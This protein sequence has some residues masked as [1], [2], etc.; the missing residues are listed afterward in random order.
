MQ[1]RSMDFNITEHEKF[2]AV[3]SDS[4]LPLTL[5]KPPFVE[6]WGSIKEEPQLSKKAIKMLLTYPNTYLCEE[7]FFS[8][9]FNK[10]TY[11][12]G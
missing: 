10:A 5:K 12:K 6:I 4:T 11:H 8:Y 2:I 7:K 3:F 1:E 9:A